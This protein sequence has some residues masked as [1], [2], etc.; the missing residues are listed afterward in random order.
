M[1][2]VG[3]VDNRPET[4]SRQGDRSVKQLQSSIEATTYQKEWFKK[5]R[6]RISEGEP[7]AI[8]QADTPHEVF[9]AMDIPV[10]PVQ[11][12]SAVIAAKRLS[13]YYFDLMNE[14]GYQ[15]NLCR[16]C[17]LPLACTMDH[18]PERAPWGGLPKP[19]VLLA[20]LTCDS[21]SK[22]FELW[23]REYD[24][25]FFPLEHTASI[26]SQSHWWE[27]M[28]HYWPELCEPHRLDLRVEELKALI[29][30][31]ELTTAKTLNHI[32]FVEVME[33]VNEE[34]EYFKKT[35]DLIAET[36][37]CPVSLPDQ[38]PSTMIP[39][40]HR[41]TPWGVE[42]ARMFYEEVKKKVERGEAACQKEK[43]RL[44][45]IGAGLWHNT[46]FYQHFEE[47]YG[48]VFVCSIYLSN[49]A[50]GYARDLLDDPLRA[51]ASRHVVGSIP[52]GWIRDPDWLL[53]EAKL[54]KVNGAVM[55]V[56]RS[57]IRD[58][59]RRFTKIV[60]E[61][62]GIPLLTIYADVVDAREWDDEKIKSQVSSFIEEKLLS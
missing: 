4:G 30:F 2:D 31:L 24:C 41:G 45:W 21:L 59:G 5:M 37:P 51:L 7:F 29:R 55:I 57:C 60:F 13:P 54:H 8:A 49:A 53:K 33:L 23:A 38:L 56:N 19:T 40:W 28:K 18:N 32:R 9:L 1:T 16:Y 17:C 39:Q 25:H 62:A 36:V 20:E 14:R 47:K 46:A 3:S 58:I 15:K 34:V 42:H 22:I 27:R 50:D 6:E 48:A 10:V 43:L 44:M 12:W 11:W 26:V 61:N 35:R 52:Y